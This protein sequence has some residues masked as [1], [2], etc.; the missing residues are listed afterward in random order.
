MWR[1][2][3]VGAGLAVLELV[4]AGSGPAGDAQNLSRASFS[5][6]QARTFE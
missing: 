3:A 5:V 4:A 2:A 6:E 1:D